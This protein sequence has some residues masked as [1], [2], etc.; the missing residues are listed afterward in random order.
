NSVSTKREIESSKYYQGRLDR[1]EVEK[2][3][4]YDDFANLKKWIK[5]ELVD[6]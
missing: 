5:T 3:L 6:K 4:L 1:I 2:V